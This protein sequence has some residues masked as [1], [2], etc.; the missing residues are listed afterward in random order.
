MS[1]DNRRRLALAHQQHSGVSSG[2]PAHLKIE[3]TNFCNLRCPFCPHHS[4]QREIGYM[5]LALYRRI[6]EQAAP[7]LEF[8]Y[9]HHL[10]E[11]LF[12]PQLGEFIALARGLK[13]ST[14]LSTNATFLDDK[15][16]SRLLDG[17]LDF[18][19]ISLDAASEK[20]YA[21][22]RPG[23]DF[24]STKTKVERFLAQTRSQSSALKVTVQLIL[25][26]CNRDEVEPFAAHWR[27]LGASVMIK[28]ARDFAGQVRWP[29][30]AQKRS[31]PCRMPYTELTVLWDGRVVPCANVVDGEPLLGS[32]ASQTL[33]EIWNGAAMQALRQAHAAQAVGHIAVCRRCPG[34]ELV[35]G[36]FVA[37]DVYAQ[38][39]RLYRREDLSPQPGLS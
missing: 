23:G 32:L 24:W 9:L 7:E 22:M 38:R 6:L 39:L 35:H 5:E 14:G 19:V 17:G 37:T 34:Q 10:G 4:M 21:T 13:I 30:S 29:T 36:D 2:R 27:S 33:D 25:D 28:A 18:L 3:L 12:H 26:E 31:L 1:V 11:S 20:S 16:G 15:R 8:I